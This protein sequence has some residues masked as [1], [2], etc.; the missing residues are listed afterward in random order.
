MT[1]QQEQTIEN[2]MSDLDDAISEIL[3]ADRL[4]NDFMAELLSD[5]YSGFDAEGSRKDW[6][7]S[8]DIYKRLRAIQE[9]L[10]S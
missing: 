8:M 2:L 5:K 1:Q 6:M 7:G 9:A 3:A 4:I 10:Y